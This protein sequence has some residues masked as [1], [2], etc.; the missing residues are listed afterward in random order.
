MTLPYQHVLKIHL[1]VNDL[2]HWVLGHKFTYRMALRF[3]NVIC[4]VVLLQ[5]GLQITADAFQEEPIRLSVINHINQQCP[6]E[7]NA[8]AKPG[9]VL[10]GAMRRLQRTNQDF[11]F[12]ASEN[13]DY[14]YYLESVNGVAGNNTHRTYWQILSDSDGTPTPTAVGVGCYIPK[15]NEHIIFNF[16]TW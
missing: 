2:H 13:P 10:L 15:K 11:N 9:G 5:L 16:T 1:Q 8:I 6:K 14:G 4:F 7:Y 12:T 3:F